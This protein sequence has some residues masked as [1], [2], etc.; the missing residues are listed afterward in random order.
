MYR[1]LVAKVASLDAIF[2]R[3]LSELAP[4]RA[5]MKPNRALNTNPSEQIAHDT[6]P[7]LGG[8]KLALVAGASP[9]ATPIWEPSARASS[10]VPTTDE[11]RRQATPAAVL[12]PEVEQMFIG[13][14]TRPLRA[15]ESHQS[16]NDNREREVRALI[17][18]L[19][20]LEAFQMRR[21]LDMDRDDD[22]LVTA[23]R[24]IACERRQRLRAF[25]ASPR[26]HLG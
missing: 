8:R 23:F 22:H 25:L 19:E 17:T 4:I 3:N 26:R 10:A 2:F 15:D 18:M 1:H 14:L 7:T 24:R 5:G 20:P 9:A 6:V 21:R 13:V 11:V 16:G 12:R